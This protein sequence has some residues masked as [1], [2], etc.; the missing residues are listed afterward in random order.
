M[1]VPLADEWYRTTDWSPA[2]QEEFER[3]LSRARDYNRSQY[4]KIKGIHLHE[5]GLVDAA[6]SLWQR[7]L[8]ATEGLQDIH[9][10]GALEDLGDSY[11]D[12]DPDRAEAYYR[13][14][15]AEFPTLNATTHT[16]EI[17]L[18]ELLIK[19]REYDEALTHLNSFLER[20]IAQFPNVLFRWHLALID[21]ATAHQEKETVQRAARVA[22]ELSERGPVFSRHKTVGIVHTDA[23]TL[24][25]LRKLAR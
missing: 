20:N 11:R 2:G 23:K 12:E 24:R 18:A 17:A 10:A 6:R 13:Q 14:L 4:L 8:D 22:L 16:V 5:A 3:R 15:L 21:I 1:I 19:K 25:R 7:L 9:R